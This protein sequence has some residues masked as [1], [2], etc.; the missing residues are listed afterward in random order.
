MVSRRICTQQI[1]LI[2]AN[3]EVVDINEL[4]TQNSKLRILF[5]ITMKIYIKNIKDISYKWY[6]KKIEI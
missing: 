5:N 1:Y 4:R 6:V 2:N 3:V